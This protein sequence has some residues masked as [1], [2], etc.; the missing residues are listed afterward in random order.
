M[1]R[2]RNAR[3][4]GGAGRPS[5]SE[6]CGLVSGRS[7]RSSAVRDTA[8]HA[9]LTPA[10]HGRRVHRDR[11]LR[12]RAALVPQA[13]CA[14][15]SRKCWKRWTP[16]RSSRSMCPIVQSAVRRA[17][18]R[19]AWSA[20]PAATATLSESTAPAIGIRTR[21]SATASAVGAQARPFGPEQQHDPAMSGCRRTD[22]SEWPRDAASARRR[23]SPVAEALE[24]LGQRASWTH[25]TWSTAPIE[26]RIALR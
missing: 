24:A 11:S 2:S 1:A 22:R 20:M 4:I 7:A 10:A 13:R 19:S 16:G 6:R 26:V 23:G 25:G 18:R 12:E 5:K 17:G 8:S 15:A 3:G 14:A 21:S 9:H